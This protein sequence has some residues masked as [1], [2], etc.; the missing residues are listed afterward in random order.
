[1][2][3]TM[4]ARVAERV[5]AP[6]EAETSW[7]LDRGDEIDPTLVVIEELGGGSRYEVYRAWDRLLFCQVAV[8]V[9][10]PNRV[11]DE[12]AISGMEREIA[13]TR[14]LVHPNLVRLLRWSY[15]LPRPYL[16][17]EFITAQTLADHLKDIGT[18]SIPEICLLGIRIASALHHLHQSGVL[19]L[20]VKPHNLTL[21]DP[22]RLLDLGLA[23]RVS[24]PQKLR[25]GLGT[26][27]YMPR[28]Q[29]E[30]GPVTPQSDLFSLG[31]TI[32]EGVSGM[33]PFSA[34]DRDSAVLTERYPQLVEDAA[35]LGQ[36]VDVPPLLERIVM[37]CLQHD[38]ARRPRSAI[39]IAI[40][41]ERV[42][43]EM[44]LDEL[45]AWPRGLKVQ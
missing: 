18:V 39:D 10:R 26:P 42:L 12:P 13:L 8:K 33:R 35:P 23:R 19:H 17:Q 3:R 14:E 7:D 20:D 44:R 38:P 6:A 37:A 41:L 15:S 4:P 2:P 21:G 29:C 31:L 22:P 34:G 9:I 24:G 1:M 28:E 40:P 32:Y 27:A 30:Q 25:R 36:M 11:S 45:L 16:V 5:E 43:E